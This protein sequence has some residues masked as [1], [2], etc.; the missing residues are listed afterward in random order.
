MI[1][2]YA[3]EEEAKVNLWDKTKKLLDDQV[4]YLE[5]RS[6]ANLD[7]KTGNAGYGNYTK[8]SR[9]V[10]NW[11][12]M[13]CQGQP[14]CA[15]YQS[16]SV[17]KFSERKKHLKSWGMGFTTA[18]VSRLIPGQKA[19]GTVRR[20]GRRTAYHHCGEFGEGTAVAQGTGRAE[21]L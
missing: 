14:W 19:H 12:L 7:S 17:S 11:G 6:N 13:G 5:K 15:T 10:N 21:H 1:R 2:T 18:T 20:S 9:D 4:G 16:G 8:Y 3:A